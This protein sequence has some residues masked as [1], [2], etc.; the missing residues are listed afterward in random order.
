MSCCSSGCCGGSCW[1]CKIAKGV[2]CLLLLLAAIA[3]FIGVWKTHFLPEGMVFGTVQGSAALLTFVV[4]LVA[5]WKVCKGMCPC[6]SCGSCNTCAK[7]G[8]DPCTCK[9]NGSR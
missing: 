9:K 5:K 2:V 4:A 1:G 8:H 3:A 7:C 6:N